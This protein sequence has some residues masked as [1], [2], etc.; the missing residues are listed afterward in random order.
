MRYRRSCANDCTGRGSPSGTRVKTK[1]SEGKRSGD[2]ESDKAVPALGGVPV[3]LGGAQMRWDVFP[4]T[5]ADHT[6][7]AIS[8]RPSGAVTGR[9]VVI[10]VVAIRR[11]LPSISEHVVQ[12]KGVCLKMPGRRRVNIPVIAWSGRPALGSDD[13]VP[14]GLVRT[15]AEAAQVFLVIAE[16]ETRIDAGR[17]RSPTRR[18]LPF[19]L[20]QQTVGLVGLFRQPLCIGIGFIPAQANRRVR[21]VLRE[22]R[23]APRPTRTFLG[24]AA[25]QGPALRTGVIPPLRHKR[26][27]LINRDMQLPYCERF[28]DRNHVAWTFVRIACFTRRRT[29]HERTRRHHHHLGAF[30]AFLEAVLRLERPFALGGQ[31]SDETSRGLIWPHTRRRSVAGRRQNWP[32]NWRRNRL[33]WD[34]EPSEDRTKEDDAEQATGRQCTPRGLPFLRRSRTGARFLHGAYPA[35]LL[36]FAA[37][38]RLFAAPFRLQQKRFD[39]FFAAAF[40]G[41]LPGLVQ[42]PDDVLAET[43]NLFPHFGSAQIVQPDFRPVG[44][45]S[46]VNDLQH[47]VPAALVFVRERRH[48]DIEDG[49]DEVVA[50]KLR[51]AIKKG[52]ELHP[53]IRAI[54][55]ARRY[56][57]NEEGRF[58]Y[59]LVDLV[60]PQ[61][62]VRNGLRVL[63][64]PEL[65]PELQTQFI[66]DAFSQRRQRLV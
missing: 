51:F 48:P 20:R 27:K 32:R 66:A 18:I 37:L 22:T 46:G 59:C 50:P 63:P 24:F 23:I 15:V 35:V 13:P 8:R 11:P 5:T 12:A 57:R 55:R 38:L 33:P 43:R 21:P 62:A 14:C 3:S 31:R 6:G 29:H 44:I 64:K 61:R 25:F 30:V 26:G 53:A 47:V 9:I 65:A 4:G 60:F 58:C 39:L 36:L 45:L 42:R 2:A 16:P 10:G 41:R 49:K 56:D 28:A 40:L 52:F 19:G 54:D 34:Y 7:A 17:H 1:G